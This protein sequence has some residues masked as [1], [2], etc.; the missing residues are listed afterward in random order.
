MNN[1]LK[2]Y[3]SVYVNSTG[4]QGLYKQVN[5]ENKVFFFM[6]PNVSNENFIYYYNFYSMSVVIL[7][8]MLNIF[9][10]VILEI[11]LHKN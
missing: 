4:V 1:V 6:I 11:K 5:V 2:M 8:L 3:S 10:R 9:I 7:P